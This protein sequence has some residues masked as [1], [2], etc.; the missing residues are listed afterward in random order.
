[1][2]DF[3]CLHI[4]ALP[5]M[6]R[7]S[8]VMVNVT[9]KNS[10]ENFMYIVQ[11]CIATAICSESTEYHSKRKKERQESKYVQQYGPF[12]QIRKYHCKATLRGFQSQKERKNKS[13]HRAKQLN[14]LTSRSHSRGWPRRRRSRHGR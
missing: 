3:A 10:G 9:N 8:D 11:L 14:N 13:E 5:M 6:S 12:C 2:C 7:L 4:D 1:M